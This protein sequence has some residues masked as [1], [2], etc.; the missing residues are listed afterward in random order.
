MTEGQPQLAS[1][2]T[3]HP[4][5]LENSLATVRHAVDQCQRSMLKL[6]I[7]VFAERSIQCLPDLNV[8][9]AVLTSERFGR[10]RRR[11]APRRRPECA[12]VA[13]HPG[14]RDSEAPTRDRTSLCTRASLESCRPAC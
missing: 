10:S 5:F 1:E 6:T 14:T 13:A 9:R 7:T 3:S 11:R 4:R 12:A 8:S 2:T